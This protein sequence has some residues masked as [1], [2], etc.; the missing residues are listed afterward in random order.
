MAFFLCRC[1][2]LPLVEDISGIILSQSNHANG[3][4]I[5]GN[6]GG[7]GPKVMT[8]ASRM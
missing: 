5:L 7:S 4:P 1:E 8:T 2:I 3:T 6:I